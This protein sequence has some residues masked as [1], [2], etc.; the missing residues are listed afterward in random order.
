MVLYMMKYFSAKLQTSSF[1]KI[2]VC[3]YIP[4]FKVKEYHIFNINTISNESWK[5]IHSCIND[6]FK[7]EIFSCGIGY[8]KVYGL[9]DFVWVTLYENDHI[10]TINKILNELDNFYHIKT[11]KFPSLVSVI[12]QKL[13]DKHYFA[14]SLCEYQKRKGFSDTK[15]LIYLYFRDF[16][17]IL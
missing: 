15:D 7:K 5:C 9:I 16:K 8:K 12:I 1:V 10:L 2:P 14:D 11:F 3:N 6:I 17:N 4:I 13:E